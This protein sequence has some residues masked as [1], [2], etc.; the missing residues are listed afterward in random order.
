VPVSPVGRAAAADPVGSASSGG[1]APVTFSTAAPAVA[2]TAIGVGTVLEPI[3][4]I[5]RP[6]L[7]NQAV[8]FV[9]V[10]GGLL[11]VLSAAAVF[12]VA[13]IAYE[14]L[15]SLVRPLIALPATLLGPGGL[16]TGA[17]AAPAATLMS[18]AQ[19]TDPGPTTTP[20][21]EPGDVSKSV[22]SIEATTTNKRATETVEAGESKTGVQTS[23]KDADQ[24]ENATEASSASEPTKPK[25]THRTAV[26][27]S[28]NA[29][30]Q[31]PD[32]PHRAKADRTGS[33]TAT[34]V[35]KDTDSESSSGA[36]DSSDTD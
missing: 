23:A 36:T 2:P 20:K 30:E 9:V 28:S 21:D 27:E 8:A 15:A 29:S 10:A 17:T 7:S 24:T 26:R 35:G 4:A 16:L 34:G 32:R 3:G 22:K 19:V 33:K 14:S 11:F 5:L 25:T 13:E 1:T 6:L 18:E 12:A 31:Q